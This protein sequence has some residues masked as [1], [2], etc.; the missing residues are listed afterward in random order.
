[1][2]RLGDCDDSVRR[3]AILDDHGPTGADPY[4]IARLDFPS[5]VRFILLV[6]QTCDS[7]ITNNIVNMSYLAFI[8]QAHFFSS[9][10]IILL[11]G[12]RSVSVSFEE[13]PTSLRIPKDAFAFPFRS[14]T[15]RPK[16]QP[17]VFG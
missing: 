17:L 5:K 9:F 3:E 6:N 8:R 10:F 1:M 4:R 16:R 13:L 7:E 11:L 2:S 15:Q 14:P 12:H